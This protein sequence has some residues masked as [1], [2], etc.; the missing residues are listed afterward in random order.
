[1]NQINTYLTSKH[2]KSVSC[3]LFALRGTGIPIDT[4][5]HHPRYSVGV[6]CAYCPCINFEKCQFS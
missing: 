6:L 5:K 3:T 4:N 1:V 2:K